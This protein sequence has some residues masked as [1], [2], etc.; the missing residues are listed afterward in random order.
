MQ[1]KLSLIRLDGG[2]Q[3]RAA[4]N[5]EVIADYCERMREGTPFKPIIAY[6]DGENYWLAD[7]FHRVDAAKQAGIAE[8]EAEIIQGTL[9]DSQWHS[10]SVNKDHGL[11]RT[12]EDKVRS[13]KA[14]LKHPKSSDLSNTEIARH[15]GVSEF[16]I[17]KHRQKKELESSSIESKMRTVSRGGKTYRQNTACIGKN[18]PQPGKGKKILNKL[19]HRASVPFRK[20]SEP[21]RL[22][23]VQFCPDNP[24]TAAATLIQLFPRTFLEGIVAEITQHL[25]QTGEMS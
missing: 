17:R 14:A 18:H 15:C 1:L 22:I 8:I 10:Y 16:L 7:G 5:R 4:L 25:H 23:P 6:F 13:V 20:H 19:S 3:P 9:S 2:T 21:L 12:N 11:R 24:H